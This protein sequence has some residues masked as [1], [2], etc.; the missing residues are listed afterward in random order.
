MSAHSPIHWYSEAELLRAEPPSPKDLRAGNVA[1]FLDMLAHAEGTTRFG[2]DGGYNVM[3]GGALFDSYHDHPRESVWL[4][5]YNI[6]STAAGRYQFL[7]RTWDDLVE[8]FGLVDFTPASQDKGA[9]YL[10]RQCKALSLIHA[11]RI[12]EA[13]SA[14]RRIW[15]S[16]PGAEYGQRE[17]DVEE[18]LAV[19]AAAG[20]VSTD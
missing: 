1:A 7:S 6:R 3:V 5:A 17:L 18:L 14:C 8:R 13:I 10:I 20:G 11:G 12:R 4:P 2:D 15:A 9:V 16:L 19:Y